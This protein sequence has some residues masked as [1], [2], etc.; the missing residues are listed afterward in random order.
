MSPAPHNDPLHLDRTTMLLGA[1]AAAV[2]LVCAVVMAAGRGVSLGLPLDDAWIHAAF[3]RNLALDQV[4]GLFAGQQSGGESSLL[5]PALLAA[6]ELGGAGLAPVLA[7]VL[8]AA[9]FLVLPGVAAGLVPLRTEARVLAVAVGLCGPLLFAALSGMETVPALVCGLAALGR[10]RAGHDGRAAVLAG[11]AALLRPDALLLIPV[12]IVGVATRPSPPGPPR[13]WLRL[14]PAV[15]LSLLAIATLSVLEQRFPPATLAGRRWIAGL[16]REVELA[17]AA[18]G[19]A[20]LIRAWAAALPADLGAGRLVAGLPGARFWSL[21]WGAAALVAVSLGAVRVVRPR[22]FPELH[23][24]RLLAAWTVAALLFYAVVLPDRGHAGRYQLQV[25]VCALALAVDGVLSLRTLGGRLR[26]AGP[27]LAVVL[28]GGLVGSMVET[29]WLWGSAVDHIN[30]LHVKVAR[31]LPDRT[32]P[33]AVIAVFDVGAVAYA[34][35]RELV[36]LSGLTGGDGAAA[37]YGGDTERFLLAHRASHVLLPYWGEPEGAGS[38]RERLGIL[39]PVRCRLPVVATDAYDGRD[40]QRQ[41]SFTGNAFR[42][43]RMHAVVSGGP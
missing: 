18:G 4:W 43:L 30:R 25:C 22:T 36:D 26:L 29:A 10:L 9:A 39:A 8:G 23:G 41:F 28:G 13:S 37:L 21:I 2:G 1:A 27:A 20:S 24:L 34:R 11:L 15:A 14:W 40:W 31:E 6:G 35:T 19:L 3:A 5:W 42:I 12:L 32:G 7:L 17:Q 38:L 33:D 16:P